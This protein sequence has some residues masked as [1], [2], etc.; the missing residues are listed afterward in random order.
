MLAHFISGPQV[1][2]YSATTVLQS[3]FESKSCIAIPNQPQ[4]KFR[5]VSDQPSPAGNHVVRINS[6]LRGDGIG[7]AAT[8]TLCVDGKQVEQAQIPRTIRGR[9]SLDETFDVGEDTG[10]P[11]VEDCADKMPFQFTGTLKKFAYF[12]NRKN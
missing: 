2:T 10:T 5:V 6:K 12:L 7:K 9:F 11:V 8:A 1:H 4:D 3:V